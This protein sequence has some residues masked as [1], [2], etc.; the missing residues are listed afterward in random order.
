ML[1][2]LTAGTTLK[3]SQ[4]LFSGLI[5]QHVYRNDLQWNSFS[6]G[7]TRN[8]ALITLHAKHGR[9]VEMPEDHRVLHSPG[10]YLYSGLKT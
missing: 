9:T 7:I 6:T 3:T 4:M 5:R 8:H 10:S 2:S 1:L